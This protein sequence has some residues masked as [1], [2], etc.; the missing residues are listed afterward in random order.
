[1][2]RFALCSILTLVLIEGCAA[3]PHRAEKPTGATAPRTTIY[4][5]RRGWHVDIGF[6]VSDLEAPLAA[7]AADFPNSQYLFFGFGDRRYL[8]SRNKNFPSM[9]AAL[10]PG[11]GIVLVTALTATP[12]QGFGAM[13]VIRLA[14]SKTRA[15]DAQGFV[16][17]SMPK[18]SG[19][20]GAYAKGPYEGSLY[21]SAIPSYS[22]VHTCN[23]WVAEALQTAGLPIQSVGVVFA[24]QLWSQLRR[25]ETD[26]LEAATP[27]ESIT[28]VALAQPQ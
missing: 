16:W 10:W 8:T 20:V 5:A 23:T 28:A 1:M 15:L 13:H 17:N 25:I 21:Y 4:M 27:G 26:A 7:L 6:A 19:V 11:A 24:A 3:M 18:K 22:A 2:M 12:E 9:L 14:I